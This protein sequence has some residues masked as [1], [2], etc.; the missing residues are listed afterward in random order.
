MLIGLNRVQFRRNRVFLRPL[1]LCD[2]VIAMS[3]IVSAVTC[4]LP[5]FIPALLQLLNIFFI[6]DTLLKAV[7]KQSNSYHGTN[8]AGDVR[9]WIS[10]WYTIRHRNK[11]FDRATELQETY[12]Q[13]L[14]PHGCCMR[15]LPKLSS[16]TVCTPQWTQSRRY[17]TAWYTSTSV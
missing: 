14:K 7:E 2:L 6:L 5:L 9:E 16:T 12:T 8:D 13:Q 3:G 15:K 11:Q 4:C 1:F 10:S 17:P